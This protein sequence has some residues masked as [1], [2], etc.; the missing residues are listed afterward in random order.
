MRLAVLLRRTGTV[1][2]VSGLMLAALAGT[3]A[4]ASAGTA[5]SPSGG[6]SPASS[7][8]ASSPAAGP[9]TTPHF[10]T[11]PRHIQLPAGLRQ[12]CPVP[13]SAGQMQ[14]QSIGHT[15]RPRVIRA[16]KPAAGALRPNQL[17]GAYGL[18]AA[19]KSGGKGARIAIVEAY[20]DSHAASDLAVYRKWFGLPACKTSTGCLKIV[21]QNGKSGPLPANA[22]AWAEE[23]SLDLDVVSAICPN[24]KILLVEAN[25][26][27][28]GNMSKAEATAVGW[29]KYV[30]NSWGSGSEFTG[31]KN[32]DH[33]FNHRGVVITAAAGD[34]GYGTQW[35]AAYRYVTAVGGTTLDVGGTSSS[36]FTR[37]SETAW[38]VDSGNGATASGCSRF[39]AKPSWQNDTGCPRRTEN[40]V[41]ADANPTTGAAVYD[42]APEKGLGLPA[43][44]Q[45]LGGTSAAAPLIAA[46]YALANGKA[47]KA[48]TYPVHYLYQHTS[49]LFDV[50]SG[51]DGTCSASKAYLCTAGAGYDGPTGR[52]APSGVAAFTAP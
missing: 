25:S 4:G 6:S 10:V 38:G 34:S 36:G 47:P 26:P 16:R 12:I 24:C 8:P 30:S 41:A 7:S 3:A 33:Y 28:V 11:Q 51:S 9:V 15:A 40:D 52:G 13:T 44:W 50:T 5:G 1:T 23:A 48:G 35:P 2:L 18:T 45:Q 21:N 17:T 20:N 31:E 19:A 42:S 29:T 37:S 49:R 46:V 27:G 14:C 39:E 43:G 32:Y 22:S